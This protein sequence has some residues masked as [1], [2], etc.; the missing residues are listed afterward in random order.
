MPNR[1]LWLVTPLVRFARHLAVIQPEA[2]ALCYTD[3]LKRQ[4]LYERR[5]AYAAR[6]R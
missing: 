4:R 6:Q 2:D 1:S 5:N 3:V